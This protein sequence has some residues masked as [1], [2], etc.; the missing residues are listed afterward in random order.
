MSRT[1]PTT[2]YPHIREHYVQCRRWTH[3]ADASVWASLRSKSGYQQR[4]TAKQFLVTES[5]SH[6]TVPTGGYPTVH[7]T[8]PNRSHGVYSVETKIVLLQWGGCFTLQDRRGYYHLKE[9]AL[10]RTMWRNRFGR[11]VGPVVRQITEWMKYVL[12]SRP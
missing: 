11:G 9:D 5:I 10:D 2:E 1:V 7:Q 3:L 12:I 4:V 8:L 6:E